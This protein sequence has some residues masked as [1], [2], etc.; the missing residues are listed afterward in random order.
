MSK[1]DQKVVEMPQKKK[2]ISQKQVGMSIQELQGFMKKN[3][4]HPV[5]LG[6]IKNGG[7]YC[8]A[9]QF[10]LEELCFLKEVINRKI[11]SMLDP[12]IQ[13]GVDVKQQAKEAQKK[14]DD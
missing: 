9:G 7:A 5:L 10:S 1:N 14:Q 2:K 13:M 12:A 11:N 3:R 6:Y 4:S 8:F